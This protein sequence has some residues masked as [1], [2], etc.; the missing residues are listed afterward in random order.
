VAARLGYGTPDA[1]ARDTRDV[2]GCQPSALVRTVGSDALVALV[3]KRLT[4]LPTTRAAGNSGN[5]SGMMPSQHSGDVEE[6]GDTATGEVKTRAPP[7]GEGCA[8]VA[9]VH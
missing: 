7:L 5:R 6:P 9:G 3:A 8:G 2:T 1:L 4:R